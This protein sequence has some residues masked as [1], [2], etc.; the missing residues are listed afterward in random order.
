M[1]WQRK[2]DDPSLQP[3]SQASVVFSMKEKSQDEQDIAQLRRLADG[4][5]VEAGTKLALAYMMGLQVPKDYTQAFQLYE[6]AAKG[7]FALAQYNLAAMYLNGTGVEKDVEQAIIWFRLA[8]DQNDAD[9]QFN[10]GLIFD[11]HE[12]HK[13]L[14][15][16]FAWYL[17]AAEN[18][19]ARA[20]F[21]LAS[22]YHLG[23]GVVPD[24][25]KAIYWYKK[26]YAQGV[27]RAYDCVVELA[28]SSGKE[29]LKPP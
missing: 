17:M 9:A 21:D 24:D 28:T 22:M 7:G 8:A 29:G 26:A 14:K 15:E 18:G 25:Q 16:A 10:L 12:R 19:S 13:D 20:Q 5:D 3:L 6:K 2:K 27:V 4:G 23:R 11:S 1:P